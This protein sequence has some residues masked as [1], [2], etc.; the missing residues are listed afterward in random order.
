MLRSWSTVFGEPV[1]VDLHILQPLFWKIFLWKD[2]LH[3]AFIDA[4][5]AVDACLRV[6][7]QHLKLIMQ[8]RIFGWLN[9]INGTD[10]YTCGVFGPNTRLS[11]NVRHRRW[12]ISASNC[13]GLQPSMK[14]DSRAD[15]I[16]DIP[17]IVPASSVMGNQHA[18]QNERRRD[19]RGLADNIVIRDTGRATGDPESALLATSRLL[20][21]GLLLS[22]L[23]FSFFA[24]GLL[25]SGL[26]A[27]GLLL[28]L[29]L[30]GL[31]A[32]GLLLSGLL[33]S[34]LLFGLLLSGLLTSGLLFGLLLSGLLTS[35]LLA[36]GLSGGLFTS[37][38]L[39]GCFSSS[40]FTGCLFSCSF[41]FGH[42]H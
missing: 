11:N 21:G 3:G 19:L 39:T 9:A 16:E 26:L 29:F 7:I 8:C 6:D 23:L 2:S 41:L 31:L 20:A 34:G 10:I 4:K 36:C 35:G 27:S 18:L 5:P 40:L 42:D 38:L 24:S 28:G 25:L 33:A 22:G 32:S 12:M 15:E 30:S 13:Y 37:R 1:G 17:S 14:A